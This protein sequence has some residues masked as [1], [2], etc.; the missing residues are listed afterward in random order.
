[1]VQRATRTPGAARHH[2]AHRAIIEAREEEQARREA[3][4]KDADVDE[5]DDGV[6]YEG[7]EDHCGEMCQKRNASLDEAKDEDDELSKPGVVEVMDDGEDDE[8]HSSSATAA[9]RAQKSPAVDAAAAGTSVASSGGTLDPSVSAEIA[10]ITSGV[11]TT[12]PTYALGTTYT[13]GAS[14]TFVSGAPALPAATAARPADYPT[15]DKAPPTDSQQAQEWIQQY[16]SQLSQ[17]PNIPLTVD[18]AS[19]SG[20][21]TN[22]QNAAANHWWTCGGYTTSDDVTQCPDENTWGLSYD[23]GPSP[24][25]PKLLDYMEK[26]GDLKSTFFIVGSRAISRP[27]ILQYEY[28]KGHQL[29]VHTWSH[30]ALTTQSNEAILLE[31]LWTMKVIKTITGVTPNTMRPP[32]G[33]IDDRVRYICKMVGLTPIIWTSLSS[34]SSFDTNDWKIQSGVVT[35]AQSVNTFESI[36]QQ[37]PSLGHGYIVLEHDLYQQSVELAVTVV[38]DMA[39]NMNPKQTLEPIVTCLKKDMNEA[40]IETS[41]NKSSPAATGSSASSRSGGSSG[42]D[43]ILAALLRNGADCLGTLQG[44]GTSTAAAAA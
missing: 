20:N 6:V 9:S 5:E 34:T 33:D 16:S 21:P 1:M 37:A 11:P 39:Q 18:Q 19:C 31:L 42:A 25:T 44:G 7:E 17:A 36:L 2:K 22:L 41:T 27:D 30:T 10:T 15:L 43:G 40:Y 38:L 29:S 32:Y 4:E 14:N 3:E 23:D 35:A 8:S 13:A 24:Y 26:H 28:M 12:T